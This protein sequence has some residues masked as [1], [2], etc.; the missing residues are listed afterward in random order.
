MRSQEST[1]PKKITLIQAL[2]AAAAAVF[3]MFALLYSLSDVFYGQKAHFSQLISSVTIW[4]GYPK[5][6]DLTIVHALL[7]GLPILFVLFLLLEWFW[8]EKVPDGK[9]SGICFLSAYFAALWMIFAD[10]P[11][12]QEYVFLVIFLAMAYSICPSEH[13]MELVAQVLL[14]AAAFAAL[15]VIA[16]VRIR[17]AGLIWGVFGQMALGIFGFMMVFAAFL[18]KTK[19]G[20]GMVATLAS[21]APFVI[22]L[23]PLGMFRFWYVYKAAEGMDYMPL[24]ASGRWKWLCVL[25]AVLGVAYLAFRRKQGIKGPDYAGVL[26]ALVMLRIYSLPEGVMSIDYFH[27]GEILLPMQQLLSFGKLPYRD[28]IPIHGFC[29][30]Y[31]GVINFL[32]FDNTYLSLNAAKCLGDLFMGLFYAG[33][34]YVV[35]KKRLPKETAGPLSL[36]LIWL[37]LPYL[38]SAGMRYVFLFALFLVC[39]CM[40]YESGLT[41]CLRWLCFSILAIAWNPSIGGAGAMAFCPLALYRFVKGGGKELMGA[42]VGKEKKTLLSLGAHLLL[43]ICFIPI[44]LGIVSYL[45]DNAATTVEANGM[46]MITDLKKAASYFVPGLVGE[47][48]AF[49]MMAF[50]GLF[51]LLILCFGALKKEEGMRGRFFVLLIFFYVIA[52]Y[53]Y[54]RFDEGLRTTVLGAFGLLLLVLLYMGQEKEK[55]GI[56]YAALLLLLWLVAPAP[57]LSASENEIMGK[58]PESTTLTVMGKETQDPIVYLQGE[59]ADLPDLGTGF[60]SANALQN[61]QNIKTVMDGCGEEV[62]DLTNA[63][64]YEVIFDKALVM[65][66]TSAYNISNN[67]MQ[68]NAIALLEEK[69]PGYILIAPGITFD[70]APMSL[71]CIFLY[72]KIRRMG[73]RPYKYENVIYMVRS[74]LE[75]PVPGS[76][77]GQEAFAQA[78]HKTDLGFLPSVWGSSMAEPGIAQMLSYKELSYRLEKT[79][80]GIRIL[81]DSPVSPE[82]FDMLRLNRK[83]ETPKEQGAAEQMADAEE[84]EQELTMTILT[85]EKDGGA[86]QEEKTEPETETENE[87]I[88]WKWKA[89]EKMLLPLCTSPYYT[90]A[91]GILG[92]EIEGP[93]EMESAEFYGLQMQEQ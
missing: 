71:R 77:D 63:V 92:F 70:E 74:D 42:F 59:S 76:E 49:F 79:D 24:F 89:G 2:T 39:F 60:L 34:L 6:V 27:N 87:G 78:M 16:N 3:S 25:M 19:E 84:K 23:S 52:E 47:Q 37:V 12:G 21:F 86:L 61:L 73:Y 81:F 72:Q 53:S 43:G 88:K 14:M 58:I 26:P 41:F 67:R 62:L 91:Q 93:V 75:N 17:E 35:L 68:K 5:Q 69:K 85:E 57:F 65:P 32:F 45:A 50:A 11:V 28:L 10:K 20:R 31:Y 33:L 18:A 36:L 38:I 15:F 66:Y 48:G 90:D 64:A 7:I 80:T 56:G 29:D 4:R 55:K 51:V 83:A 54:V 9:K 40:D 82:A 44:F 30:Y 1:F 22:A 13:Y 8:M 46:E